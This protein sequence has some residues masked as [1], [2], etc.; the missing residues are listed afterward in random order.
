M[1]LRVRRLAARSGDIAFLLPPLLLLWYALTGGRNWAFGIAACVAAAALGTWLAPWT[2]TRISLPG[3]ARFM[4][5]FLR[6]SVA[7]GL[8]VAWR[9]LHP[10]MPLA[11]TLQRYPL[12]LESGPA[13][14]VFI[15]TLNLLPGT[16]ACDFSESDSGGES[17][18]DSGGELCVHCIG[19]DARAELAD[20]ETHVRALFPLPAASF[21]ENRP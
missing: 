17:G 11:V 18:G 13:R 19:G 2:F 10:A 4:W 6:R 3:L 15:G 14:T 5:Y 21:P 7:G 16:L 20:L 1:P 8:D 9:A 12:D